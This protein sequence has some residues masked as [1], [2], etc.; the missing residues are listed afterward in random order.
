M[1]S[2]MIQLS[3]DFDASS[4]V[5][6]TLKKGKIGNKTVY[7]N[8]KD[9]KNK[10]Y[11]QLPFMRSPYG[12]SAYTDEATNKTSYSLDLSIDQDNEEAVE[13]AN[14]LR[15]LDARIVETVA[16]NAK[17]WLGKEYNIEVIKEALYKPIVRPGKDEYPDTVKL[18]VM[19][20]PSGEFM[21]EAY[22][23]SREI[24]PIDSIEKGQRCMCIVNIASIWFIDNKCGVS[25]RLS[26]ALFQ[27]S[28]KLPSFAFQGVST[29]DSKSD[30]GVEDEFYEE[31]IEV[32]E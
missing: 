21:A 20:K 19:T 29:T 5:F 15:E 32:D 6:S 12:L 23:P 27:Q 3:K 28:S 13:L 25:I 24:V 4:V 18:K 1:S 14:K 17:E 22:N 7:I 8:A 31:E 16:A 30:E 26:Q 9:G 2:N 10:L 11:L